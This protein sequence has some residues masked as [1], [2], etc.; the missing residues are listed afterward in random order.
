MKTVKI[1]IENEK[2]IEIKVEDKDLDTL[3]KVIWAFDNGK[4][5][6]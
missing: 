3:I 6:T 2:E 5:K 1:K 4:I